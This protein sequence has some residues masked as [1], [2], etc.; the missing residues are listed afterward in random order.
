MSD[1]VLLTL[2]KKNC[3]VKLL[4]LKKRI[5][6][7]PILK[8]MDNI[9][10]YVTGSYA[11]FEA[12]KFSDLD[13]FLL[14]DGSANTSKISRIDKTLLDAELIKITREMDFGEFSND[15]QYLEIHHINNILEKLGCSEDDYNNYFTARLLL[16]LE[17]YPLFNEELYNKMIKKIISSYF[18]DYHDHDKDFR[19]IFLV[20]DVMRYYK[21]MC[22]NYEH[23]RNRP[24]TDKIT[25]NKAHLKN[26]KLKF[27]RLL[28]C[29]AT[30][31]VLIQKKKSI[32]P[33]NLL[34]IVQKTPIDKLK[35]V[36]NVD[37]KLFNEIINLYVWFLKVTDKQQNDILDWIGK[38][39]NRDF[40]FEKG[41][42]FH[43]KIYKL[44][45]TVSKESDLM[46]LTI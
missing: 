13:I 4:E 29:Y 39:S 17:S 16:L 2:R 28:T 23:K 3:S 6:D 44:L 21:T 35:L 22:M 24:T 32:N 33:N 46:Y 26:L 8:K 37:S 45:K 5:N 36:Q 18:R 20:N 10:I 40:A 12:N 9:C 27:S 7:I 25:K 30:I 41:R 11:R 14:K 15:G 1:N 31:L 42:K 38:K 34:K 43:K 19:P